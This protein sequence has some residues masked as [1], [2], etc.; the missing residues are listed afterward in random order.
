VRLALTVCS[1]LV[2]IASIADGKQAMGA[3]V[4]QTS[5]TARHLLRHA[6]LTSVARVASLDA[7]VLAGLAQRRHAASLVAFI[8]LYRD[9]IE[10]LSESIIEEVVAQ[11]LLS[12][13]TD[14]TLYEL[15]VGFGLVDAFRHFGFTEPRLSLV[16]TTAR[17]PLSTLIRGPVV[18]TLYWQRS[19]WGVASTH[20]L[21]GRFRAALEMAGLTP[22]SMRPDLVLIRSG[23]P[24]AILLVEAKHTVKDDTPERRGLSEMLAYMKD[25]EEL[26]ANMPLPI[27][28]VVAWNAKG[29]P[30]K[31]SVMM[32]DTDSLKDA[33]QILLQEWFKGSDYAPTGQS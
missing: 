12:P 25:T 30:A 18:L 22:S 2:D 1:E 24:A 29:R 7:A 5:D 20:A 21:V 17:A 32:A 31:H 33:V 4:Q 9:A 19:V 10:V 26:F 14:D 13:A 6:K 11:R 28:L 15:M 23:Q 16:G 8:R 3:R 27:G